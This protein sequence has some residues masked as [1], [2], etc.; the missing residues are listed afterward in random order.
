[1][2]GEDSR[3]LVVDDDMC[4][5]KVLKKKLQQIDATI[6]IDAVSNGATALELW[7]RHIYE[8]A[9]IDIRMPEISGIKLVQRLKLAGRARRHC[10]FVAYT[11]LVFSDERKEIMDPSNGF[12]DFLGKPMCN[13]ELKRILRTWL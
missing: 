8:L 4:S 11:A 5:L 12:N 10:P 2:R 13:S 3:I 7:R 1:M 6:V 9:F